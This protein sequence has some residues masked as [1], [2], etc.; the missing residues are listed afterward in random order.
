MRRFEDSS[1]VRCQLFKSLLAERYTRFH[2]RGPRLY[3]RVINHWINA[4][5]QNNMGNTRATL[6]SS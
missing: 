1:T 4:G 5:W 2:I 3:L 6:D